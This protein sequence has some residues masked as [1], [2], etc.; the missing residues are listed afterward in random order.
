MFGSMHGW[1]IQGQKCKRNIVGNLG[2]FRWNLRG[3]KTVEQESITGANAASF[4]MATAPPL[5][6]CGPFEGRSG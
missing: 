6:G 5:R 3:A 1:S 2:S 4:V